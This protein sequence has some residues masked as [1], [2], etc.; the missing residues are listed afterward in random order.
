MAFDE[1]LAQRIRELL[2]DMPDVIEKKMFGGLAFMIRGNMSVGIIGSEL[3]VHVGTDAYEETLELPH[4]REMDFTGKALKGFVYVDEN[5]IA[6]DDDLRQWVD[7]GLAF[8]ATL[9]TK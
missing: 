2:G 5:G 4:A 7:R 3:M 6:E 8:V 1:G 9:P